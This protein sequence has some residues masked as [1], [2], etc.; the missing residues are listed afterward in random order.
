MIDDE[1]EPDS[2]ADGV[3]AWLNAAA[4]I[5]DET[6]PDS[7]PA[8]D[9][10]I[11]SRAGFADRF[12]ALALGPAARTPVADD[13]RDVD[14]ND[15][16]IVAARA[17]A[18]RHEM[19]LLC[20]RI[21]DLA[22]TPPANVAD[23]LAELYGYATNPATADLFSADRFDGLDEFV[24]GRQTVPEESVQPLYDMVVVERRRV[25]AH[26]QIDDPADTD[27]AAAEH[28]GDDEP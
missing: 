3:E 16:R 27:D 25:A 15:P 13:E 23:A 5:Q 14:P 18:H 9:E 12:G 21:A 11:E 10:P 2:R 4:R 26:L 6:W 20:A 1:D 24:S 22:D 19:G 8:D 7:V 28:E 17:A